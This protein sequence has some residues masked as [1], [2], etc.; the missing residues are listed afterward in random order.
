MKAYITLVG[1]PEYRSAHA[2]RGDDDPA[3]ASTHTDQ[4]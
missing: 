3:R 4:G 1:E 2:E